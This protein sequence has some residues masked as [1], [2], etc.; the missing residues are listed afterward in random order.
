MKIL[1]ALLPV[2]ALVALTGTGCVLVSGQFLVTYH[3]SDTRSITT[4]QS[5]GVMQVD[6]NTNKTYVANRARLKGLEDLAILGD[7]R[8]DGDAAATLELWM[9]PDPSTWTGADQ[10]RSDPTAIRIWGPLTVNGHAT[11]H[12]GWDESAKLFGAGRAPLLAQFKGDGL[13]TVYAIGS[14][15]P[16]FAFTVKSADLLAV[17]DVGR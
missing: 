6:L 14:G 5:L 9:T 17:L 1:R 16:P 3:L 10:V 15:G 7:I 12:V 11:R 2:L 4:Q 13:F 8:N